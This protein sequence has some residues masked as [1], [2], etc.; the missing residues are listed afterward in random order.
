MRALK[1]PHDGT[2]LPIRQSRREPESYWRSPR[3][4]TTSGSRRWITFSVSPWRHCV[5]LRDLPAGQAMSPAAANVGPD[6]AAA[7]AGSDG[8][9]TAASLAAP[10]PQPQPTAMRARAPRPA[11]GTMRRRIG[12]RLR[13][14]RLAEPLACQGDC[15]AQVRVR[16]HEQ[17]GHQGD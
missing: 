11:A 7:R 4:A 5:E 8:T 13:V 17:P 12:D 3:G 2:K 6:T 15:L 9:L 14:A 10:E 16:E 1:R